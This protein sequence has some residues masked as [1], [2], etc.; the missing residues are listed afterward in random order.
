[1][2]L[3]AKGFY[4]S[5]H[6]GL[7]CSLLLDL[8][9]HDLDSLHNCPSPGHLFL[10]QSMVFIFLTKACQLIFNDSF[11]FFLRILLDIF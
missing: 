11:D 9:L 10:Y 5:L 3:L 1:M 6:L 2:F 7:R 8:L 4:D